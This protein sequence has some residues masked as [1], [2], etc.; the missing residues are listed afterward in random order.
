MKP[1]AIV[2]MARYGP[3]TRSA[4]TA[5]S[6]PATPAISPASGKAAQKPMPVLVVRMPTT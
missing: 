3:R 5:S 2:T 6:A 4:G 1:K